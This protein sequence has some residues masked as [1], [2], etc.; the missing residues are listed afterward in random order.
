MERILKTRVVACALLTLG[1]WRAAAVPA[2]ATPTFSETQLASI[3]DGFGPRVTALLAAEKGRPLVRA[4]TKPPLGAGRAPFA[5]AYSFSIVEFAA[6]CLWLE[7]STAAANAALQENADYYLANPGAI[8]DKDNFHWHSEVL[9][10]LI[11]FFGTDGTRHAGLVRPETEQKILESLWLYC[12]RSDSAAK[13]H[14]HLAEADHAVSQTWFIKE[15]EN[16]HAQS[17]TTLWH[18][19]KIARSRADF[20][21]RRYGDG[22]TAAEHYEAWTGYAK[23]YLLE[24]AR[25]GL[26][27]EMMSV[28]YN[29]SLLKGIFNFYDFADDAELKRRT[30][31]FLDLYFAYW[32]QEQ[33]HG[34]AGGGQGRIYSDINPRPSALGFLF[35][36]VGAAPELHSELL[37]AMTTTYRPSLVV[38]DIVCDRIGRGTYEV[39]QR[40]LG[41]AADRSHYQPPDYRLRTD[42]GGNL[43][44]SYCAPGFIL[45]TTMSEARPEPDWTM[46]SSQNRRHGILFEGDP[47]A[48][49]SPQCEATHDHRAYNTQWSV[50][51]KGTLVCQKLKSHRGAGPMRV[52]FSAAGLSA[53]IEQDGWALVE[54]RGAFAAVRVVRGATQ[55]VD[56]DRTV[57]GR[58]LNLADEYSPVILQ[59]APTSEYP[60]LRAFAAAVARGKIETENETLSF[61][62]IYGDRFLFPLNF[63]GKPT[64]NGATINYAPPRALDSPYVQSEWNSGVVRLSKGARTQVLD[65]NDRAPNRENL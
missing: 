13:A 30:G 12:R 39:I 16:H 19:A 2:P 38:V 14:T 26:F 64:I 46:I 51:R 42:F 47:V 25:K 29:A 10:R 27:V 17:F 32:G 21:L 3:R 48:V 58:W 7:E 24:R 50:Q 15:S 44:Y 41:L 65:F 49:I 20:R 31:L 36:G 40:P 63:S 34:V 1:C 62:S 57:A 6:R 45:G 60:S 54:S 5:R 35:F 9:L 43:R 61:E 8:Y 18:F 37:T 55:W 53:P 22:R 33:I 23:L 11:E 56:S 4:A 28:S 52:W 59:V